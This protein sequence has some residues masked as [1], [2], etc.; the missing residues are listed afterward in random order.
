[1]KKSNRSKEFKTKRRLARRRRDQPRERRSE[2]TLILKSYP[3]IY[4]HK[5][6]SIAVFHFVVSAV[7]LD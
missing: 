5:Y 2:T 7:S 6:L 4:D 1:L 3:L